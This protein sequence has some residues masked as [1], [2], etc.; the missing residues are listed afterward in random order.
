[1]SEL[2]VL[3]LTLNIISTK[4]DEELG[5]LQRVERGN[6]FDM[7]PGEVDF[8]DYLD[9]KNGLDVDRISNDLYAKLRVGRSRML[10]VAMTII[11]LTT[12]MKQ[13]L[14]YRI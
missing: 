4:L 10:R 13:T 5:E 8:R 3:K 7:E 1:M 12:G 11:M 6:P 2:V 14:L 9:D